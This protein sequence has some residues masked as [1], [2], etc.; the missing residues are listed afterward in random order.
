MK[1]FNFLLLLLV[2][3]IGIICAQEGG[4]DKGGVQQQQQQQGGGDDNK[5]KKDDNKDKKDDNK[6]KKDDNKDKKDDNKDKKDDNKDDKKDKKD[7]N[8]DKK[9]DK[10]KEKPDMSNNNY[11]KNPI[12]FRLKS[13]ERLE[14]LELLVSMDDKLD[15]QWEWEKNILPKTATEIKFT[16]EKLDTPGRTTFEIGKAGVMDKSYKYVL[17]DYNK[18]EN[19]KETLSPGTYKLWIHDAAKVYDYG[20]NP[21]KGEFVFAPKFVIYEQ[22]LTPDTKYLLDSSSPHSINSISW[23]VGS[24]ATIS[25]LSL[26]H[27]LL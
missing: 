1:N 21:T 25:A 8:K 18:Q 23:G 12:Q 17:K 5:D 13:P 16:L 2:V 15:F 3:F 9:D 22:N 27:Y 4:G 10:D 7:D 20:P 6:D 14:N 19:L 11:T 24:F 26:V